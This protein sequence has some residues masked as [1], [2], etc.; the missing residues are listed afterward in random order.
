MLEFL[1]LRLFTN[2]KICLGVSAAIGTSVA[3]VAIFKRTQRKRM[4][5]TKNLVSQTSTNDLIV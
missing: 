1:N 4:M 3:V 5:S 2:W